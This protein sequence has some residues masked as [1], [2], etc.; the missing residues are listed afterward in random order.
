[1]TSTRT[2]SP[3]DARTP[4][5]MIEVSLGTSGMMTSSAETANRNAYVHGE[6]VS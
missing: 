6:R 4:A 3:L 1:M 2:R 5:R